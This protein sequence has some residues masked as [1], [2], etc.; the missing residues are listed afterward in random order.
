MADNKPSVWTMIK[1]N[2]RNRLVSGMLLLVPFGVTLLVMRWLF[3]WMAGFLKPSV[4]SLMFGLTEHPAIKPVPHIYVNVVVSII[5]IAVLLVLLYLV[6]AIGHFVAGRRIISA[7][8]G[9][10]LRI[11]LV[12]TIYSATKQVVRAISLPD[13][14]AFKSVVLVEFPRPG[15]KAI[16]FLTGHIQDSAGRKFCKVFIPTTPN[17]TTGFFE[18]VPPEDVVAANMTTEEAFKI[19]ISGGILAPDSFGAGRP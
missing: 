5:S 4:R 9:L 14:A 7:G 6:G 11:P 19:I 16:G 13:Q 15:F 12:R 8:E 1:R 3:D 10:V 18:I 17:P 2:V